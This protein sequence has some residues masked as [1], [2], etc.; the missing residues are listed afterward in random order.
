MMR[1]RLEPLGRM[2]LQVGYWAWETATG[3]VIFASRYGEIGRS[4]ELLRQVA[5]DEPI[6]PTGFSMSVHNA[7]GALHSI[8]RGVPTAYTAIAAGSETVEAAFTEAMS[9]MADG[10]D[11]VSLVYYDEA[12]PDLYAPLVEHAEFSRAWACQLRRT[13][14]AGLS[15]SATLAD[16]RAQACP[17][18]WS[19][20]LAALRFLISDD[21]SHERVVGRR[22]W[23]WR[24]HA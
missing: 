2:A 4:V 18:A 21:A 11:S 7:I 9:L 17:S 20:D 8:A 1:R 3:P 23:Q 24:R 6:S 13:Q 12:L 10:E 5:Q 14:G 15:L 19:A 22:A 16:P